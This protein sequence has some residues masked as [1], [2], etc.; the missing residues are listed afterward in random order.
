MPFSER[1]KLDMYAIN[2][3]GQAYSPAWY[4]MNIQSTYQINKN[5]VLRVG[6][7]NL[8]NIKYRPYSSGISAPGRSVFIALRGSI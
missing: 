6:M 4:T 3:L 2:D 5:I 8:M 1:S 7:E